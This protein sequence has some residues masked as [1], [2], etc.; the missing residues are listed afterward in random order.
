MIS[1]DPFDFSSH[2]SHFLGGP[3]GPVHRTLGDIDL[4]SNALKD[5]QA[6]IGQKNGGRKILKKNRTEQNL[7]DQR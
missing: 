7:F 5:A 1:R 2:L 4:V 3:G 6:V